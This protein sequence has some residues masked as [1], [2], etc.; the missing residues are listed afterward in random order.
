[1][2]RVTKEIVL[3]SG[4]HSSMASMNNDCL[5]DQ[6]IVGHYPRREECGAAVGK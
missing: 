4:A 1:M 3:Q 5:L 6:E 2:S